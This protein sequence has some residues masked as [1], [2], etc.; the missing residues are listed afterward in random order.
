ML[1]V[2]AVPCPGAC[3][4]TCAAGQ[5]HLQGGVTHRLRV[6]EE[7][8]WCLQVDRCMVPVDGV[9]GHGSLGMHA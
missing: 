3:C 5:Q 1:P 9:G 6:W 4:C 7:V 8:W 2:A